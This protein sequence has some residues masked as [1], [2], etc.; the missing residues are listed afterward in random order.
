MLASACLPRRASEPVP[1]AVE[2]PVRGGFSSIRHAEIRPEICPSPVHNADAPVLTHPFVLDPG[3]FPFLSHSPGDE[4]V[5]FPAARSATRRW[6]WDVSGFENVLGSGCKCHCG[7]VVILSFLPAWP[8]PHV[9][10]RSRRPGG[11]GRLGRA[12]VAPLWS[13]RG[14]VYWGWPCRCHSPQAPWWE[15]APLPHGAQPR[16]P[17]HGDCTSGIGDSRGQTNSTK[18]VSTSRRSTGL[19]DQ[20]KSARMLLP[21]RCALQRGTAGTAS[22]L[23]LPPSAAPWGWPFLTW[24]ALQEM[25]RVA[26]AH[27][28]FQS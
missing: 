24:L 10:A 15:S 6:L 26:K 13:P 14:S 17:A 12:S 28:C 2:Q 3:K 4:W 9:P 27:L 19:S 1:A 8:C 5:F 22:G 25:G 21:V 23:A 16:S 18:A 11:L 20:L 7:I